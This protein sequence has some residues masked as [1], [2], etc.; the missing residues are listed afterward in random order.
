MRATTKFIHE[1]YGQQKITRE[2]TFVAKPQK[3]LFVV[4][5][6]RLCAHFSACNE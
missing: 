3:K 5:R 4:S 2:K 1:V 6:L